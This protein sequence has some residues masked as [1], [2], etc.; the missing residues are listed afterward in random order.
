M[1]NK[2][3][4]SGIIYGLVPHIGCIAFVLFSIFGVATMASL[5]R[6]LLMKSYFFYILIG[7]SLLFATLSAVIYLKKN[8]ILSMNGVKRKK[9]YLT[10]LY[11]TT[12]IVNLLFFF[13]IFPL[14]TNLPITGASTVNLENGQET[15]EKLTL[16]VNIPCSGHAPLIKG[17]LLKAGVNGIFFKFPNYFDVYYDPSNVTEDEILNLQIFKEFNAKKV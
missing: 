3:F 7:M 13:V 1:K 8:G 4:L 17:E 14:V 16:K 9:G 6:P 2:S 15:N 10:I 11:G 5:F 12:I